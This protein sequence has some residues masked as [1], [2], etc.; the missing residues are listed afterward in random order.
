MEFEIMNKIDEWAQGVF[1]WCLAKTMKPGDKISDDDMEARYRQWYID[2]T[3]AAMVADG[4]L[5]R[6]PGGDYWRTRKP[7]TGD[8]V[9]SFIREVERYAREAE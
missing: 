3:C 6:L 5:D 1:M 4:I 9:A 7:A 2:R 8:G